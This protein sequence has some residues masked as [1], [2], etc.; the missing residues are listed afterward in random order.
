MGDVAYLF[1]VEADLQMYI[2]EVLGSNT[3]AETYT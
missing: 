1:D 2:L 3:S